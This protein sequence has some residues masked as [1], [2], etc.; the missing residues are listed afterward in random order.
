[1]GINAGAIGLSVLL[2]PCEF[3][4]GLE[5]KPPMPLDRR[6]ALRFPLFTDPHRSGRNKMELKH[7]AE[8]LGGE[9]IAERISYWGTRLRRGRAGVSPSADLAH[10]AD[11]P[12]KA[13]SRTRAIIC[14]GTG[15]R[16][17]HN[18]FRSSSTRGS[19]PNGA[20]QPFV[21]PNVTKHF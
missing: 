15:G 10:L 7:L 18:N 21:D 12:G 17:I 4:G 2:P 6:I 3:C 19:L 8:M 9:Q 16:T 20:G 14:R 11:E 13:I 1:M 5:P